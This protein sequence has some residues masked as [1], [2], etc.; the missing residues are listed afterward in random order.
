MKSKKSEF[1]LQI[2]VS[3]SKLFDKYRNHLNSPQGLIR[4]RAE[5]VLKIAEKYPALE[6]GIT[7]KAEF[8]KYNEQIDIVLD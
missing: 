6:K 2:Q 3:F 4:E 1:P 8:E 7:T 5:G